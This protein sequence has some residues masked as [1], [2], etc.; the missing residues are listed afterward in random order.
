MGT[1]QH[2]IRS[3]LAILQQGGVPINDNET[4]QPTLTLVG[5]NEA[6]LRKLAAMRDDVLWTTD[7]ASALA[8]PANT[9]Y[10]DAQ[11]TGRVPA[12]KQAIAAASM[13]IAKNP[14]PPIPPPRMR[15]TRRPGKPAS[16]TAWCRTSSGCPA[17]SSSGTHSI[18]FLWR[19]ASV[20][21]EVRLLG[22][23]GRPRPLPAALV[24]LPQGRR[25]RHHR[26]HAVPLALRARQSLWPGKGRFPSRATHIKQRWTKPGRSTP[27][28]ADDAVTPRLNWRT[29]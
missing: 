21:G 19:T 24:E 9:I 27:C 18:G 17:C 3:L 13:S 28:T 11:T 23:R 22:I 14:R 10:F 7:L 2:Y 20:R 16:N 26:G 5:R 8:N 29:A 25:R 15:F 12:V 4:I 6:K 1:N